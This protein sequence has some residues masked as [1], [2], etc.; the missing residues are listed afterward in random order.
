M[1]NELLTLLGIAAVIAPI[2]TGFTEIYKRWTPASGKLLPVLSILTGAALAAIWALVFKHMDLVGVYALAGVLSGLSAVGV[3][4]LVKPQGNDAVI[5]IA[6]E[7]P[8][9]PV[10]VKDG[11]Q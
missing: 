7:V 4:N 8:D 1:Q 2:T 11:D 6:T 9:Q 5:Q 10:E 3:Y